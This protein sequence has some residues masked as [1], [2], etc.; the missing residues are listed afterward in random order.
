CAWARGGAAT[1]PPVVGIE[2][3]VGDGT[4]PHAR[5]AV[6]PGIK[7]EA[8]RDF[9]TARTERRGVS[10]VERPGVFA[11][12]GEHRA[13]P[14]GGH[15]DARLAPGAHKPEIT[16]C[17]RP[18]YTPWRHPDTYFRP[19]GTGGVG[20]HRHGVGPHPVDRG[21]PAPRPAAPGDDGRG[22]PRDLGGAAVRADARHRPGRRAGTPERT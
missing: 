3:A 11:A 13:R 22:D 15:G 18:D 6:V 10:R 1:R 7:G 9:L 4:A 8:A 21:Q 16:A 17:Q 5:V 2:A 14:E 19:S 20:G 12:A